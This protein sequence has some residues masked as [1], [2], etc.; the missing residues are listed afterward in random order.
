[1]RR[2][3]PLCLLA[4]I[5]S[6]PFLS[7]PETRAGGPRSALGTTAR[8]YPANAFPL[9]YRYDQGNLGAFSNGT[10]RA[11][12]DYAFNQWAAVAGSFAT[13]TNAGQ[14]ARDVTS[15]TDAYISG[16]NQYSDGVNPI[17]FDSDG[18]ITDDRLGVGAKNSVLGFAGSAYFTSNTNYIEGYVIING[19]LSGSGGATERQEYEATITHE[20]GHFLGLGHS[21]IGLGSRYPTMYPTIVEPTVQR[22]LNPD[23]AAA[24]SLLYP[25]GTFV[26]SVGSISGT[27]KKSGGANLSGLN[28]VALNRSTG[29]AYSTVVD[30]FSGGKPGFDNAPAANGTYT[31]RGLPPG[32][33]SVHVEPINS[34]FTGGSSVASYNAPINTAVRPEWYNAS[35]ENGDMLGDNANEEAAVSVSA[36][37]TAQNVNVVENT[38]TTTSGL[39]EHNGNR[40]GIISLPNGSVTRYAIRY[41]APTGGSIVGIVFRVHRSSSIRTNDSLIVSLHN[42]QSGSLA[43]VPGSV[44]GSV[45]IPFSRL[46]TDQEN[47][48]WLRSLGS[49]ANFSAGDRFHIAFSSTGG[50]PLKLEID[51]GSSST[52][53]SSYYVN[54]TWRN[55]DDGY[56][57]PYNLVATA[58]YSNNAVSF[59]QPEIAV[60]PTAIDF[61]RLRVNSTLDRT[62]TVRNS[63]S[64]TL[65][66]LRSAIEGPDSSEFRIVSGG[67]AASL[68]PGQSTTITVR[69][70]PTSGGGDM[71]SGTK[72][73]TLRIWS[74]DP[75]SP[76]LVSLLGQSI[77][78][79]ARL[80]IPS[81]DFGPR[82]VGGTYVI[83][84]VVLN[85]PCTDTLH[86]SSISLAG[87]DANTAFRILNNPGT[88]RLAPDSSLRIAIEF[89]PTAVREYSARLLI[90]HD[91]ETVPD[92][93]SEIPITGSG[94]AP[95]LDAD[96]SINLGEVRVGTSIDRNVMI[97]NIGTASL[98]LSSASISGAN[99]SEFRLLGPAL[100]QTIGPGDSLAVAVRF[101]PSARGRRVATLRVTTSDGQSVDVLLEGTGLA[102]ELAF[103]TST[104]DF[105]QVEVNSSVD[106]SVT[107]TNVGNA[108]ATIGSLTATGPFSVLSNLA[109]TT[110]APN[111]SVN[112]TVRFSPTTSGVQSGELILRDQQTGA[113]RRMTLRG[114]GRTAGLTV[115]QT[116]IDYGIYRIGGT[117]YRVFV[118]R[119][120]GQILLQQLSYAVSG[121]SATQFAVTD[122]EPFDLAPGDSM[123]VEVAFTPEEHG[124]EASARL[125]IGNGS[126]ELAGVDLRGIGFNYVA[127]FPGVIDFAERH[128][129][130]SYDTT[131]TVA[132]EGPIPIRLED[133]SVE[134]EVDGVEGEFFQLLSPLPLVIGPGEDAELPIRFV[135]GKQGSY[136]GAITLTTDSPVDSTLVITFF[137]NVV[138]TAGTMSVAA[139]SGAGAITGASVTPNPATDR[140][141]VTIRMAGGKSGG[142]R[143]MII[144]P[145]GRIRHRIATDDVV[146]SRSGAW[147][148]EI[149][150][151]N[152]ES[153]AYFI[154]LHT[155]HGT[156]T[157]PL[158]IEK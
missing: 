139:T 28:V 48:V 41:T 94:I 75:S 86:I 105:G 67:G 25:T 100:P 21:Q 54:G 23:D 102:G 115:D 156:A 142:I 29:A 18:S 16:N 10:A 101:T 155:P 43:G 61:G 148:A 35:S 145:L 154:L 137:A 126:G 19:A 89:S 131:I 70:S 98:Q 27:V 69:F 85:N 55:F 4:L 15:A 53:Q 129:N 30:Y 118:V 158:R 62:V 97:R 9:S 74:N 34:N 123:L 135:A 99:A 22:Q 76:T 110:L 157:L 128:A 12:S 84:T 103:T 92:G 39:V 109:G 20:V 42:N 108:T 147:S 5:L 140:V 138:D 134:A 6:L 71:E 124:E 50:G 150:T 113:E 24:F 37:G 153:G 117:Y 112:A 107:I 152:F 114:E 91:D 104:V 59:S 143:G 79:A 130:R 68:E 11:I 119:N 31:L 80:V 73:A 2:Q 82:R 58:I 45:T 7:T 96:I 17:V 57:A 83:D 1:M 106:R 141:I 49:A 26:G 14:L 72:S 38:S 32:S 64:G 132:N 33:Y 8:S 136:S 120:T 40:W 93:V 65:S 36:G 77:R 149:D 56:N 116:L 47:L 88:S 81:I 95:A 60:S 78:P 127:D 52:N 133:Y 44:R 144:D 51:N 66:I 63:G 90:A 3:L 125:S 151:R 87:A 111:Q 146:R 13:F 46:N 122:N 121:S